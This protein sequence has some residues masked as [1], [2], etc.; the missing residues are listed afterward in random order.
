[1]SIL[2]KIRASFFYSLIIFLILGCS[3]GVKYLSTNKQLHLLNKLFFENVDK[4]YFE[5]LKINKER[6]YYSPYLVYR[7]ELF[8]NEPYRLGDMMDEKEVSLNHLN[9][10]PASPLFDSIRKEELRILLDQYPTDTIKLII[11]DSLKVIYSYYSED[12]DVVKD[13]SPIWFLS[14]LL[15]TKEKHVYVMQV[16]G[17]YTWGY[18]G[19]RKRFM[20]RRFTKYHIKG[21]KIEKIGIIEYNLYSI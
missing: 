9:I 11:P 2:K 12:I 16:Y 21:R 14:P 15:P 19:M 3:S 13:T 7:N 20:T 6:V 4:E 1:M 17:Y 5:K 18:E 10:S 8:P